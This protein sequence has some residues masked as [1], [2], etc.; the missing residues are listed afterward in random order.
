MKIRNIQKEFEL[1]TKLI[2]VVNSEQEFIYLQ[3]QMKEISSLAFYDTAQAIE[4]SVI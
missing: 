2:E 1:I 4:R 3:A